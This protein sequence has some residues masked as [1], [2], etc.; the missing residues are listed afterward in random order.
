MAKASKQDPKPDKE[1]TS[2]E[3]QSLML[4]KLKFIS[5]VDDKFLGAIYTEALEEYI[6][7]WEKEN[8]KIKLKEDK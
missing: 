2:F 5:G 3:I 7:K 6:Q 4:R 8:G 1:K